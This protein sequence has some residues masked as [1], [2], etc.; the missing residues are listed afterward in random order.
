MPQIMQEREHP[1]FLA[2]QLPETLPQ[3]PGSPPVVL[4]RDDQT[5]RRN[6]EENRKNQRRKVHREKI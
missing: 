6:P 2:L 1:Q 3:K 5:H 4:Q